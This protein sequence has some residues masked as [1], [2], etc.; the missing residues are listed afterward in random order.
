LQFL[1]LS[2]KRE[3]RRFLFFFLKHPPK[4]LLSTHA[5]TVQVDAFSWPVPGTSSAWKCAWFGDS[6]LGT[7]SIKCDILVS[8]SLCSSLCFHKWVNCVALLTGRMGRRTWV[9]GRLQRCTARGRT[10]TRRW[11]VRIGHTDHTRCPQ[12]VVFTIRPT[13]VVPPGGGGD[14]L[15]GPYWASINWCFDFNIW[16][17]GPKCHYEQGRQWTGAFYNNTGPGLAMIV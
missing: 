10:R 12:L 2:E 4:H 17:R 14:W 9:S 7:S 16:L 1:F 11:G 15:R 8:S 6:T 13:T 5:S 3:R